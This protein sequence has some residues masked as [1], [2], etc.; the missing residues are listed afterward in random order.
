MGSFRSQGGLLGPHLKS[1]FL[2]IVDGMKADR[3]ANASKTIVNLHLNNEMQ[4]KIKSSGKR[5]KSPI[6]SGPFLWS[7]SGLADQMLGKR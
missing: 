1:V 3:K 5:K 2:L 4:K 6:F 7:E